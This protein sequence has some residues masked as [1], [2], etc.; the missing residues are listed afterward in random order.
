METYLPWLNSGALAL[1]TYLFITGKVLARTTVNE[2]IKATVREAV[3]QAVKSATEAVME[4]AKQVS[5]EQG[6]AVSAA[7][8]EMAARTVTAVNE[9][10]ENQQGF[11]EFVERRMVERDAG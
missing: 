2:L 3:D 4:A 11:I 1:V 7:V 5:I 10:V 8:S 6:R 9:I